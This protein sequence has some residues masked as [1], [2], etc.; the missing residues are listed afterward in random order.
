MCLIL[1][2]RPVGTGSSEM[3]DAIL[4]HHSGDCSISYTF[5]V[6]ARL[7]MSIFS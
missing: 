1:T 6:A 2:L 5:L 3:T 4:R 7:C